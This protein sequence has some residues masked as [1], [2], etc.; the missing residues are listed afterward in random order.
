MPYLAFNLNDGNEFVFDLLDE[1]LSLGRDAKNDIVIDNGF[2][3]GFHAEFL[4]QSDGTYEMVD[5]KSSNGTFLNGKR[6]ERTRLRGGDRVQFGQL[7]ARFRDRAPKGL[8]PA[9]NAKAASSTA[10]GPGTSVC[11]SSN[12]AIRRIARS[13]AAIRD[14]RQFWLRASSSASSVAC[15]ACTPSTSERAKFTSDAARSRPF[16]NRS[17]WW[18]RSSSSCS[19]PGLAS[20]W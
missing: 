14:T 2:I 20:S 11:R 16:R 13:V 12:A 7:E 5:L 6:V 1:R 19:V 9:D 18:A 3:S 15:S 10:T 17:R 4:K 8:A